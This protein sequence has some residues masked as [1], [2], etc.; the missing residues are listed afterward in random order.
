MA[1]ADVYDRR[2]SGDYRQHLSGYEIARWKALKHFITRV[3]KLGGSQSVL[4]YGAGRGLH[5]PLWQEVFPNAELSF[6]DISGVARNHFANDFPKYADRYY[7]IDDPVTPIPQQTF[8]VV[9]SVEV[10]EHVADLDKYLTS[11]HRA[12]KPGGYFVWTTPCANRMSIEHI[13]GVL[14][15]KIHTTA[16]GYRRWSWE[17]PTHVRRLRTDE[18]VER[19]SQTGFVEP[20][21]RFR[22]HLFS[23]ICTNFPGSFGR[24]VRDEMMTWDYQLFRCLPNAASMLGAARTTEVR[25]PE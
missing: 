3:L 6:C 24:G 23:M 19:L 25:P 8:D 13:V 10:M 11:I 15:G 16:E 22:A 1:E 14:T 18:I 7:L 4:D 12:L 5:L 17:D 20:R 9:V 2:Y 21:F